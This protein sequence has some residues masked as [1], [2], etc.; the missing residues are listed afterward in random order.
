MWFGVEQVEG[1]FLVFGKFFLDSFLDEVDEKTRQEFS[2][3]QIHLSNS[4][5]VFE[6]VQGF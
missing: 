5:V 1:K 2:R 4:C 3:E 6:M